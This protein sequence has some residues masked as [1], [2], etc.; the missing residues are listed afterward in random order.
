MRQWALAKSPA[1]AVFCALLEAHAR[2]RI[3]C[4]HSSIIGSIWVGLHRDNGKENGN[5][6]IM[7]GYMPMMF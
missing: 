2:Q 4:K 3:A 5:Y 6:Y 7:I 1:S